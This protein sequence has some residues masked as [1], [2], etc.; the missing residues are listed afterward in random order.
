MKWTKTAHKN[1]DTNRTVIF[2]QPGGLPEMY[3]GHYNGEVFY[4]EQGFNMSVP[5][6][7]AEKPKNPG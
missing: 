2:Y 3:F 6:Y 7:W 4:D 5:V 1:P